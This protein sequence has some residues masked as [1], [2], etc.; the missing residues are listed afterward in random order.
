[1]ANSK[2]WYA[3]LNLMPPKPDDLHVEG[4]V[5]VPNPGV[6]PKLVGR[7]SQ[8]TNP[9]VL[10]LNLFLAQQAGVWPPVIS[11]SVARYDRVVGSTDRPPRRVLVYE[12]DV[13][14]ADL[15]VEHVGAPIAL[16]AIVNV[17][18]KVEKGAGVAGYQAWVEQVPIQFDKNTDKSEPMPLPTGR[19]L[20]LDWSFVGPPGE[21][22]SIKYT[23]EG[24]R[25][26]TA[27]K[28]SEVPDGYAQWADFTF[29][30]A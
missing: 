19:R 21:K 12:D 28:D 2:N 5:E 14:V 16:S 17:T 30:K 9:D 10:L 18:F 15:L 22:L 29:I 25:E 1:M 7:V 20:R 23:P 11:W 24:T 13:I 6:I 26:K 27:V 8:N 4:L 3:W